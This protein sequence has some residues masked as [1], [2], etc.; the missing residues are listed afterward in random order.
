LGQRPIAFF[1]Y[2]IGTVDCLPVQER[3]YYEK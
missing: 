3:G 2:N 1:L